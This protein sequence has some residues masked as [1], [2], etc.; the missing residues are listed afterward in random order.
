MGE[1][2]NYAKV[3]RNSLIVAVRIGLDSSPR[4]AV[5]MRYSAFTMMAVIGICLVLISLM[6]VV[7]QEGRVYSQQV[8]PTSPVPADS[9]EDGNVLANA[10]SEAWAAGAELLDHFGR[11]SLLS[12]GDLFSSKPSRLPMTKVATLPAFAPDFSEYVLSSMIER[13]AKSHDL[14]L[15]TFLFA[16][17]VVHP[18]ADA[19]RETFWRIDKPAISNWKK[20]ITMMNGTSYSE[21]EGQRVP[22]N[23]FVCR[24]TNSVQVQGEYVN[25]ITE[26]YEV[27][28]EVVPN[29][30]IGDGNARY[31]YDILRCPL[32]DSAALYASY[33]SSAAVLQMELIRDGTSI[34][35][36]HV[37][38]RSRMAGY[39]ALYPDPVANRLERS[40]QGRQTKRTAT[41]Q[42]LVRKHIAYSL[43]ALN[44]NPWKGYTPSGPVED[45]WQ[46]DAVYLCVPGWI[47]PPS[48]L[49]LPHVMEFLEHHLNMGVKHIF[50][51]VAF[52]WHSPHMQVLLRALESYLKEGRVSISSHSGDDIDFRF[53]VG[54]AAAHTDAL[55]IYYTNICL[56]FAKGM[57]E[58]VAIWD[59]DE[60]F[61]PQGNHHSLAGMLT[62]ISP[63]A[64]GD[65]ANHSFCFLE[66]QSESLFPIN[67]ALVTKPSSSRAISIN[68]AFGNHA[69]H[70]W[71]KENF[72]TRTDRPNYLAHKKAIH[73]TRKVFY[74]GLHNSGACDLS[75]YTTNGTEAHKWEELVN[76]KHLK[77][78]NKDL[79]GLIYHV[80]FFRKHM[81]LQA[82]QMSTR[83]NQYAL[84]HSDLALSKLH[85]R[86]VYLP[87]SALHSS[88][89]MTDAA[90]A[91]YKQQEPEQSKDVKATVKPYQPYSD[92]CA[93]LPFLA[94]T[95]AISTARLVKYRDDDS[96]VRLTLW[97]SYHNLLQHFRAHPMMPFE[98]PHPSTMIIR[99]AKCRLAMPKFGGQM[100][101]ADAQPTALSTSLQCPLPADLTASLQV[102]SALLQVTLLLD[103]ASPICFTIA[104]HLTGSGALFPP[105]AYPYGHTANVYSWML[106]HEKMLAD[107][108][109]YSR[110]HLFKEAAAPEP[111][112]KTLLSLARF[113]LC[114]PSGWGVALRQSTFTRYSIPPLLEFIQ[115][116]LLIGVEHIY[117]PLHLSM[118]SKDMRKVL[119]MLRKFVDGGQLT[120]WSTDSLIFRNSNTTASLHLYRREMRL[121]NLQQCALMALQANAQHLGVWD[122]NQFYIPELEEVEMMRGM[123]NDHHLTEYYEQNNLASLLQLVHHLRPGDQAAAV[124]LQH[125]NTLPMHSSVAT[126][127]MNLKDYL[128]NKLQGSRK[129]NYWLGDVYRADIVSNTAGLLNGDIFQLPRT[130]NPQEM[131]KILQLVSRSADPIGNS[132]K[133][134]TAGIGRLYDFPSFDNPYGSSDLQDETRCFNLH[135]VLSPFESISKNIDNSHFAQ[136]QS[137]YDTFCRVHRVPD[138]NATIPVSSAVKHMLPNLYSKVYFPLVYA[139]LAGKDFDFYVDA[140]STDKDGEVTEF[141][142]AARNLIPY[143]KVYQETMEAILDSRAKGQGDKWWKD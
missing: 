50:L 138:A 49:N 71:L 113:H 133:S 101:E 73:P 91:V 39:M 80:Q 99:R 110:E 2:G 97:L 82:D 5:I 68:T 130:S 29:G 11:R 100:W 36:F 69:S 143:R 92:R 65:E 18:F 70:I 76:R 13:R 26:S 30:G 4:I 57:A 66:M 8:A 7:F 77:S 75:D 98:S 62:S 84:T 117:L 63:D 3:G 93:S 89:Y 129:R 140:W 20:A 53:T 94:G 28:A 142:D 23:R 64:L 103:G 9:E 139:A 126:L 42:Q 59:F 14:W 33:A 32:P 56:Y 46:M 34:I 24:I 111:H 119:S 37:P 109:G 6:A 61:I 22:L 112:R 72:R 83:P 55:K 104:S 137:I 79:E 40:Y 16:H 88:R 87:L 48:T 90:V 125:T 96:T 21:E 17:A 121:Q 67:Q 19:E 1:L 35:V 25:F 124:H 60:F 128:G 41:I 135:G 127:P 132:T 58:Y 38:W 115:H 118:D 131:E 95:F 74:S 81:V 108:R 86:G 15:T 122:S 102:H 114:V 116:H 106:N 31:R 51:G 105:P 120:V 10:L 54:G 45:Q 136:L 43:S 85:A 47:S 123:Y 78:L 44:L 134:S 52:S 12:V 107:Q 141:S 27:P